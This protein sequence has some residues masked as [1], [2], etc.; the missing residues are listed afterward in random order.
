[1]LSS[2]NILTH[3]TSQLN[4]EFLKYENKKSHINNNTLT[5]LN[6]IS[7]LSVENVVK[8]KLK[9]QDSKN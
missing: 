9:K 4:Y 5:L 7:W 2:F 6:T 1:M 8:I 3:N